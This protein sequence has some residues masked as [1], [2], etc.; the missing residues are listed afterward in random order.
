M[1]LTPCRRPRR[2]PRLYRGVSSRDFRWAQQIRRTILDQLD[3]PQEKMRY[4]AAAV[5]VRNRQA[6][7]YAA[8][9]TALVV[10]LRVL[11][12]HGFVDVGN[13]IPRR[14]RLASGRGRGE[15]LQARTNTEFCPATGS[16]ASTWP[17]SW[18]DRWRTGW[19]MPPGCRTS[20]SIGWRR[21][22]AAGPNRDRAC[23]RSGRTGDRHSLTGS[24]VSSRSL[25]RA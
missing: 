13:F 4:G 17:P 18:G 5:M 22:S 1:L 10:P 24:S 14:H 7:D 20:P 11:A 25:R 9:T 21:V 15:R 3:D 23:L 16:R 2:A 6:P 12:A 8:V 19:S